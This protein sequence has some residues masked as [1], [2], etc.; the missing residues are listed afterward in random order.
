MIGLL[1]VWAA[2][3]YDPKKAGGMDAALSTLRS[4]PFGPALLTVVALGIA[5]F[6]VYCLYWARNAKY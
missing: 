5:A 4:Q 1:F 3:S 6:G 2:W